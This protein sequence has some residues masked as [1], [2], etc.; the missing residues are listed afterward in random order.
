MQ[1]SNGSV[2]HFLNRV[3]NEMLNCMARHTL[4]INTMKILCVPFPFSHCFSFGKYF[5]TH[6]D[7]VFALQITHLDADIIY[8]QNNRLA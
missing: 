3:Q 1:Y 8:T 2:L 5:R 6:S 4:H 7:F